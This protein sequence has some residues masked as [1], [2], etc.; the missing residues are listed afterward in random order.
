MTEPSNQKLLVIAFDDQLKA[1]EFL[2]AVVR[3]Q[4]NQDLQLHDAVFVRRDPDGSSHVTETTDV[5]A[6][7]GAA[8]GG[9]WGALVG[10]LFGGPVGGLIGGAAAAA[11][12]ALIAKLRDIG[13]KDGTIKE[14]RE[15]VPPGRTGLA[16]LVSRVSVADL[17]LELARFPN[18]TLVETDLPP[19]TIEAVREAL[20]EA[21]RT[22]F[23]DGS[24]TPPPQ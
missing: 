24:T 23:V 16:L 17:Q 19:A 22:K 13:I 11:G 6:G 7:R 4:K 5:T 3:L 9:V 20:N 10:L 8:S 18:T 21:N 1:Q 2:L 15:A 14:L 12:G